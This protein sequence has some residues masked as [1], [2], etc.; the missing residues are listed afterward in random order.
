[1]CN[2]LFQ[3]HET[4]TCTIF[5]NVQPLRSQCCEHLGFFFGDNKLIKLSL[6][7]EACVE[8][9]NCGH[10]CKSFNS[11]IAKA[12]E[13]HYIIKLMCSLVFLVSLCLKFCSVRINDYFMNV[14]KLCYPFMFY[15]KVSPI[16]LYWRLHH[17]CIHLIAVG[18]T[19]LIQKSFYDLLLKLIIV[20]VLGVLIDAS[21]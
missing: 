13:Y 9:W 6:L 18:S 16:I 3:Q 21:T 12:F 11:R 7:M 17:C 10:G 8:K 19:Y 5:G 14:I 20:K 4:L 2:L 1:V 15:F